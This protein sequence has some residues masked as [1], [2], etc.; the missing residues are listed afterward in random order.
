MAANAAA[1]VVAL[2]SMTNEWATHSNVQSWKPSTDY[3]GAECG[4]RQNPRSAGVAQSTPDRDRTLHGWAPAV[5]N[6]VPMFVERQHR[7][8]PARFPREG[9]PRLCRCARSGVGS[10]V[11]DSRDSTLSLSR[12][13]W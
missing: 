13:A 6:T 11:R 1:I 12:L 5:D 9:V 2:L 4:H 10:N 7:S 8:A 3:G